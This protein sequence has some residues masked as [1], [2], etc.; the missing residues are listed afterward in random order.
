MTKSDAVLCQLEKHVFNVFNVNV[1]SLNILL[2]VAVIDSC[3]IN[4]KNYYGCVNL[5]QSYSFQISR[6]VTDFVIFHFVIL[7]SKEVL[8]YSTYYE[9]I[10]DCMM[11]YPRL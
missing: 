8:K 5:L 2:K 6:S 1:L 7:I 11:V 3:K 10:R 9:G 4:Q